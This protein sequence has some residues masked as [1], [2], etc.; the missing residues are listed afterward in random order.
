MPYK[1]KLFR[2][3]EFTGNMKTWMETW[4]TWYKQDVGQADISFQDY[5]AHI[6]A[7]YFEVTIDTW[8]KQGRI[9]D[10]RKM[11]IIKTVMRQ[12]PDLVRVASY[13]ALDYMAERIPLAEMIGLGSRSRAYAK[14]ELKL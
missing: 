4:E 2:G 5:F 8:A 13:D 12:D 7:W 1:R 3:F 6:W 14:K 10:V 11:N 9:D